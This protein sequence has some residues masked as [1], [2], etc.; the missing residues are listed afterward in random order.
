MEL[1]LVLLSGIRDLNVTNQRPIRS[2]KA[3]RVLPNK[4][5][6][7]L[8]GLVQELRTLP[9]ECEWV[10]FKQNK[11][12]PDD[13]GEYISALSNSAALAD[14]PFAY[15][16]WGIE[17]GTHKIVGTSFHLEKATVGNEQI[18]SW[19]IRLL[20]PRIDFRFGESTLDGRRVVV[21]EIPRA[22]S[23]PVRFRG[24]AFIRIGSYKKRLNDFPE[25]ERSLWQMLDRTPF[26]DNVASARLSSD[27]VLQLIDYPA[28]FEL[29]G[30]P[31]PDAKT[32]IL[33]NLNSDRLILSTQAGL[34][35]ITNLGALL[36]ARRMTDFD[37]VRRKS[38]RVIL[39]DG[40]GRV[41]TIRE[42]SGTKGYAAGFEEL[43][44][45][46]AG[47]L[48]TNEVIGKAL[49]KVVPMYP[50]LAVRELV[51]NALIHQDFSI[52]GAG[53]MVEIFDDR[54]EISNPGLPLVATE[55]FLD[56]PPRSRNEEAAS[57]MRR[58]GICEER[59]SG[60]D[61]VV[62]QT[63]LY[64]LPAPMFEVAGNATRSILF[65]HR[66]LQRMGKEDRVRACYLHACL[67]YVNHD[68]M[69]NTTLRERFGIE[70]QNSATASRYIK[71]AV[72]SGM[73]K[74]Y[75]ESASRKFMKYVPFWA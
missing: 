12:V 16:V 22:Y 37:S 68:Y 62:S 35:D 24:N 34:W 17:D 46:I 45:F 61:K 1:C 36:F 15:L 72:E 3:E 7:D 43:I 57:I 18:Q 42:H 67:R 33:Q 27:E 55:R 54:M 23:H 25:K 2:G 44:S 75:D 9:S 48:P 58:I 26:E 74:P 69:T 21:L 19:L 32:G 71:E 20:T 56:N 38:C 39:Y 5:V 40:T 63:E 14:Q 28:Y 8:A 29:I 11:A 53:P 66:P 4:K 64:Q 6:G 50:E 30:R 51:A 65:A 70:P 13:I 10:E 52:S 41:T 73:I 49:R 59:G 47:H 60:I 31:L